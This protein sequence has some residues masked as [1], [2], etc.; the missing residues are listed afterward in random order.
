MFEVPEVDERRD[1]AFNEGAVMMGPDA[2]MKGELD[3][4]LKRERRDEE[5]ADDELIGSEERVGEKTGSAGRRERRG[6]RGGGLL[7]Q[8]ARSKRLP[9]VVLIREVALADADMRL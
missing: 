5:I 6:R 9:T 7:T 2:S 3:D 4:D 1:E 8:D